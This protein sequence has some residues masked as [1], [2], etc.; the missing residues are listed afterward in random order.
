MVVVLNIVD[1]PE[2]MSFPDEV[3]EQN[4]QETDS[5]GDGDNVP[6]ILSQLIGRVVSVGG[7]DQIGGIRGSVGV[8]TVS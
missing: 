2:V 3:E 1:G 7:F 6:V 4:R 5:W 8:H